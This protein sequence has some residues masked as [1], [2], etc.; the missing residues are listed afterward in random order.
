MELE[1]ANVLHWLRGFRIGAKLDALVSFL[2]SGGFTGHLKE[3]Y[4]G[5]GEWQE[6]Q[7][8]FSVHISPP[9]VPRFP[10]W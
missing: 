5:P 6:V 10:N 3:V 4:G 9:W 7:I 2:K 1:G 8:G